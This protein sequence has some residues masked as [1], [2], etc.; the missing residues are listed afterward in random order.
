MTLTPIHKR[1]LRQLAHQ[2]KP[3]VLIG[4]AGLSPAVREVVHQELG[5]HE[6]IKVRVRA[7][8]RESRD[9]IVDALAQ[10]F[11]AD[12]VQRVGHI[13]TLYR[14]HPEKPAIQLPSTPPPDRATARM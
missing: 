8:D 14:P 1:Y 10:D 12:L 11:D 5:H 2:R 13:V 9:S 6:L 3:T 4:A 7:E